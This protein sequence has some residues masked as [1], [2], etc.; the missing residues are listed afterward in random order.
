SRPWAANAVAVNL[1]CPD[2]GAQSTPARLHVGGA[3]NG[4][5]NGS[6]G[7]Q[8]Q[9]RMQDAFSKGA[10]GMSSHAASA[11]AALR[12]IQVGCG[13]CNLDEGPR[14][15]VARPRHSVVAAPS[16]FCFSPPVCPASHLDDY[17][18]RTV[19]V[20]RACRS[21]RAMSLRSLGNILCSSSH[22]RA[23]ARATIDASPWDSLM[24][25]GGLGPAS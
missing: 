2:E 14:Q 21:A 9:A 10:A 11:S 6:S 16:P 5:G 22:V 12:G 4:A 24:C 19:L 23:C 3:W 13:V 7:A 20:R 25:L 1:A 18:L 17:Y 15:M 8:V